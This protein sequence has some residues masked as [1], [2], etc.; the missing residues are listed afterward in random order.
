MPTEKLRREY[1]NVQK[2]MHTRPKKLL[3]LA[4][5][6]CFFEIQD[7]ILFKKLQTDSFEILPAPH[8]VHKKGL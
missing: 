3:L 1:P 4:N 2:K 7:M 6:M 5:K 8:N